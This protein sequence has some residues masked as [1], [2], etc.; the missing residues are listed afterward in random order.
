MNTSSLDVGA[1]APTVDDRQLVRKAEETVIY[2]LIK[3]IEPCLFNLGRLGHAN[4]FL[5]HDGIFLLFSRTF[6]AVPAVL[7]AFFARKLS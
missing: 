5:L 4:K 1:A 3:V 6:V 7:M 2:K